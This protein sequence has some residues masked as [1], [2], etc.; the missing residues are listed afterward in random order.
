MP[1]KTGFRL[2]VKDGEMH[3]FTGGE[4]VDEDG[5]VHGAD[6]RPRAICNPASVVACLV[7]VLQS[8]TWKPVKAAAPGF[9]QA[10]D[11]DS[12]RDLFVEQLRE[13]NVDCPW[14]V[15]VD[16]SAFDSTQHHELMTIVDDLVL[17]VLYKPIWRLQIEE[18]LRQAGMDLDRVE[19]LLESAIGFSGNKESYLFIPYPGYNEDDEIVWDEETRTI[20]Y[21]DICP[22][23]REKV[24]R[25]ERDWV[26]L[27]LNGTVLS[28]NPIKTTNFNTWR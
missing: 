23:G 17:D 7:P 2:M 21:R 12:M 3:Q 16:G 1:A 28:G 19:P 13:F 6:F 26:M 5:T 8:I 14:G 18:W 20:F 9:C 11:K 4:T 15:F 27:R 25:P 22:G 10:L 24:S